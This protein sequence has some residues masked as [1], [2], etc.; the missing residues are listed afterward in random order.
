L[1]Q[2]FASFTKPVFEALGVHSHLSDS[3][4]GGFFEMT[5]SE[6]PLNYILLV[7]CLIHFGVAF[8][9]VFSGKPLGRNVYTAKVASIFLLPIIGGTL[10]LY[11]EYRQNRRAASNADQ[12]V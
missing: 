4:L 9:L 10:V 5:I 3:F 2:K 11:Y 1:F 6:P 8:A 12:N 7:L